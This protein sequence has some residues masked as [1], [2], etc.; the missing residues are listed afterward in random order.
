MCCRG[1]AEQATAAV[2]QGSN[3][4]HGKP[5]NTLVK[6]PNRPAGPMSHMRT[7]MIKAVFLSPNVLMEP[8][9]YFI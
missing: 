4:A 6:A 3:S 7:G 1:F 5:E 9:R 8:Y 2:A